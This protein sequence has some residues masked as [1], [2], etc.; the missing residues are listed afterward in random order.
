MT[1]PTPAITPSTSRLRSGPSAMWSRTKAAVASTPA[2]MASMGHCAQLNTAWNIKNS[3]AAR[4]TLPH[5]GCSS[6]RSMASSRASGCAG[7]CTAS[8][9]MRCTSHWVSMTSSMPGGSAVTRGVRPISGGLKASSAVTNAAAPPPRTPT[10]GNTGT[11]NAALSLATSTRMPRRSAMSVMFSA[12]I[13]GRP[14]RCAS[15]TRRRFRRSLVASTTHTSKS[16]NG[17]PARRPVTMSRV[18]SSSRLKAFR[19]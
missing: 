4:I 6:A 7:D 8:C 18:I 10:V 5:S 11:P 12:T 2:L 19:L 13:T 1:L 3:S 14:R 17:S 16:G 9:T 15:S